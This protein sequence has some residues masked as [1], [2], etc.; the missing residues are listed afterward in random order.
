MVPKPLMLAGGGLC[1]NTRE[2]CGETASER[3]KAEHIVAVDDEM[4]EPTYHS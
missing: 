3:R 2:A 1:V 4:I